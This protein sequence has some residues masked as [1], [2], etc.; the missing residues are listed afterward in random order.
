MTYEGLDYLAMSACAAMHEI[1]IGC[2]CRDWASTVD[3]DLSPCIRLMTDLRSLCLGKYCVEPFARLSQLTRLTHLE[4]SYYY[5]LNESCPWLSA[6]KSLHHLGLQSSLLDDAVT[7]AGLACLTQL[8]SLDLAIDTDQCSADELLHLS[9]LISLTQMQLHGLFPIND[10]QKARSMLMLLSSLP[11]R[12]LR[13][14]HDEEEY[15][16]DDDDD[17]ATVMNAEHLSAAAMVGLL[18]AHMHRALVNGELRHCMGG[19]AYLRM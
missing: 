13:V 15:L 14:W 8:A 1:R 10:L 4:F 16:A 7:I 5:L 17:Y 18:P 3:D 2:H 11:I 9:A 19:H 12:V 6:L